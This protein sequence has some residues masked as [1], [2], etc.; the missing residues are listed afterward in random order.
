MCHRGVS[1]VG[2]QI[3]SDESLIQAVVPELNFRRQHTF[4]FS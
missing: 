4:H 3:Y 2:Y 1:E